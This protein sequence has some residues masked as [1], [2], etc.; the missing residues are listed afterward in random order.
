MSEIEGARAATGVG[1]REEGGR[2]TTRGQEGGRKRQRESVAGVYCPLG[3]PHTNWLRLWYGPLYDSDL[4]YV[5]S[6]S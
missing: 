5:S 3:H 4:I 2:G 6:E 1:G